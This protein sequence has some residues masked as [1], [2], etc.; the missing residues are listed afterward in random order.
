MSI[1]QN[2][3][4]SQTLTGV[5]G[6]E[7]QVRDLLIQDAQTSRDEVQVD[8]MENVIAI[9]KGKPTRQKSCL[10]HTWTKSV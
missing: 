4:N 8:R 6:R 9:K 2:L 3:K 7:N 1:N 10:P 5:T